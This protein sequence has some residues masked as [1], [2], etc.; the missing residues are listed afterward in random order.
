MYF[1]IDNRDKKYIEE[2]RDFVERNYGVKVRTMAEH[3]RG[4]YGETWRVECD[5]RDP[6]FLKIIYFE[7]QAARRYQ[8]C[9]PVLDYMRERG[10]DFVSQVV[11]TKDGAPFAIFKGGTLGAFEFIEGFNLFGQAASAI[12]EDP[13][14]LVPMMVKIYELPL[15]DFKVDREEYT[16]CFAELKDQVAQLKTSHAEAHAIIKANWELLEW[17]H[18]QERHFAKM[19]KSKQSKLV[20][21]S[22]DVGGNTLRKPDGS[23]AIIDWDY[24]KLSTPERDFWWY[25][26]DLKQIDDI[27]AAMAANGYDYKMDMDIIAFYAA[28]S[29]IYFLTETLDCLMF[30]P[31]ANAEVMKRLRDHLSKDWYLY[32]SLANA[33][34][35]AGKSADL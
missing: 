19:C 15:P 1:N 17:A 27:N 2:L 33:V 30:N 26:Q 12:D 11:H 9:F 22:G 31:K 18:K 28:H 10:I 25:V 21:T 6:I 8:K 5:G 13:T 24:I 34:K 20:I 14:L 3:N 32:K 23:L 16:S 29:F 4:W 35:A 7:K